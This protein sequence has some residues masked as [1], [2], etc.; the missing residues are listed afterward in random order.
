MLV[1]IPRGSIDSG[2]LQL[3]LNSFSPF[4]GAGTIYYLYMGNSFSYTSLGDVAYLTTTNAGGGRFVNGGYTGGGF[5]TL[6]GFIPVSTGSFSG[7]SYYPRRGFV[8]FRFNKSTSTWNL[9]S[10]AGDYEIDYDMD[11]LRM[12]LKTGTMIKPITRNSTIA[13]WGS[14]NVETYGAI[15]SVTIE[16][17]LQA[18]AVR[19]YGLGFSKIY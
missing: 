12:W 10:Y 18:G 7:A 3:E 16:L 11:D 5:G 14:S 8:G 17:S 19:I 4:G 15:D 9:T 1:S 13:S 6:G 2:Y